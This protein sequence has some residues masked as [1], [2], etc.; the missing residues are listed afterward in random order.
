MLSA[1]LLF[2][3]L[4]TAGELAPILVQMV[5]SANTQGL[6]ENMGDSEE[7]Q[8]SVKHTLRHLMGLKHPFTQAEREQIAPTRS[9]ALLDAL[10]F[11]HSPFAICERIHR[12]VGALAQRITDLKAAFYGYEHSGSGRGVQRSASDDSSAS[13]FRRAGSDCSERTRPTGGHSALARDSC[14][15]SVDAHADTSIASVHSKVSSQACGA[16]LHPPDSPR[17]AQARLSLT[18]ESPSS[19][20]TAPF[21]PP[22]EPMLY[23]GESWNLAHRRWSKL[24][25]DFYNA[26]RGTYDISK[27]PDIYDNIK[28]DFNHNRQ[29][30]G[31]DRA[32]ELYVCAKH[33]ADIVIPQVRT[34]N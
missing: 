3:R 27:L 18:D 12:L 23:H 2:S 10:D 32:Y 19:S 30:L 5:K 24:Y 17:H 26:E 21:P 29:I 9:A 16:E 25:K 13:S 15:T 33:M 11:V 1:F 7:L 34:K 6:L 8:L 31:F 14:P 20:S 4:A 22:P 28:Y